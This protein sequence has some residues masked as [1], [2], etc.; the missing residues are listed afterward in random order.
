MR[1]IRKRSSKAK[2]P[3]LSHFARQSNPFNTP[4]DLLKRLRLETSESKHLEWKLT[5]PFGAA[6]TKKIKCRMIKALVSFANTDGGFIVFGVDPKGKWVGFTKA[7]L[8]DTDPAMIAELINECVTPELL[9]LNYGLLRAASRSFPIL[10]VPPSSSMPHVTTKQIVEKQTDGKLAVYLQRHAVYC[11]Y[12]AKSDLATAS[13]YARIIAQ[14]TE[15]LRAEMLR[16]VKQVDVASLVSGGGGANPNS[17]IRV[18]RITADKTAPAMRITRDPAEVSGILVHEEL[19]DSLFTEINNV[20]ETNRLLASSGREFVFDEDIY[21][22]IYAERQHVEDKHDSFQLLATTAMSNLYAPALFWLIRLS[23]QSFAQILHSIEANP[24]STY[25]HLVCRIAVLLGPRATEWLWE[26]LEREW[27]T[28][29]QPPDHYFSFKKMKTRSD[30]ED[31][32]LIVLQQSGK[33]KVTVPAAGRDVAL[34]ELLNDPQQ[35][36]NLLSKTCLSVFNGD[37]KL[38]PLARQLDVLAYGA[39]LC[40]L[41]DVIADAL[42]QS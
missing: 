31:R 1:P 23:P 3:S 15:M 34:T 40:P 7:E 19:S 42:E 29:A 4:D 41:E 2:L 16:R 11:R 36:S 17:I 26:R 27:K 14:R 5:P 22:R 24:R 13:Q 30:G 33:T 37:H 32:R 20:L 12:Q 18:S 21:Y 39:D 6:V 28:H 25:M 10:H 38:R 8:Q 35:A 9:G